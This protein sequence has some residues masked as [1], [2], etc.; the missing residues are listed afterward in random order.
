MA[1]SGQ[2]WSSYAPVHAARC[3][4]SPIVISLGQCSFNSS[5]TD[6]PCRPRLCLCHEGWPR[7]S[8]QESS[9]STWLPNSALQ[10]SDLQ[11]EHAAPHLPTWQRGHYEIP[12]VE[13]PYRG[14]TLLTLHRSLPK[15]G[16]RGGAKRTPT[17]P[18]SPLSPLSSKHGLEQNARQG[19]VG[20]AIQQQA[21]PGLPANRSALA[22]LLLLS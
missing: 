15:A 4:I 11:N 9:R 14:Q 21:T 10:P 6:S 2:A 17:P 12:S 7:G 1:L 8:L 20:Q 18:K 22:S 3:F 5:W 19:R 13:V 16:F